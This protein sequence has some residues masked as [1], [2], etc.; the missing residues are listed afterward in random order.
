LIQAEWKSS[1]RLKGDIWIFILTTALAGFGVIA[2]YSA[3]NYIAETQYGDKW[4]FVKKQLIGFVL[5]FIVMFF[6][7]KINYHCLKG[8]KIG[9]TALVVSML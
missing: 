4:Y 6:C 8:K 1:R 9:L 7:G 3:S 5:G 2:I